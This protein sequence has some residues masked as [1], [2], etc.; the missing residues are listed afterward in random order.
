MEG[1]C[2]LRLVAFVAKGS[3]ENEDANDPLFNLDVLSI[4]SHA[5]KG[6][7]SRPPFENRDIWLEAGVEATVAAALTAKQKISQ[8][9]GMVC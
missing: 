7:Q 6:A 3:R 4:A 5:Y 1:K 2:L 8:L 9:P